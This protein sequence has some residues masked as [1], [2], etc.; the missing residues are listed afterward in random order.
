ME[1]QSSL[2][3]NLKFSGK[4]V[5]ITGSGTGIGQAI[6]KK[7][8]ENGAN[9]VIMGRRKEPLDQTASMLNKIIASAGSSGKVVVFPR[10]DVA[11]EAGINAMFASLK[12]QFGKVDIIVNNAGVSGPVKTFTNASVKEFREAVAIHLTGTFWTS[13]SGL[14]AMERGG[15]IITIAT[16]FTEENRYEQRPYRFRTPYT[17]AQGAKNRLAEALAWELVERDIRSI[18]TN[19]GPVHSDRIYKTVYPKAAAEF[20]RI[21]GYPGLSSIEVEKVT[22][23]ALPLLGEQD[24]VVANGCRQVAVEI[25]KARG[26]EESEENIKKLSETVAGALAKMQEI[27]EKIQNNT[28][29]MI[30]DGEFL[31]QEDVAEMVMNLCDEKIS[32]LINGRVIPND[33]VFY[34]V[35]PIVGTSVDGP[36]QPDLKDKVIILTTSSSAKKDIERVKQVARLAQ[37]AGAKQVIVLANNQSDMQEYR[38]FHN[39]AIN[40]LDEES[41]RRIFNTA[42]TKFGKIDSVIHFTGDYDYNAAFSSLSRSQW[43]ALVNNFIYIPGLITKEAVNAMAPQGAVEE[44]AKYKDSKGTVVIVGPDAPVGKKISGVLRARA[45]VFRGALRPYTA[46]VNQELGDVLGSSIKLHL[47]LAG[48]SEGSEPD[49]ARLHNSILNLAAGVALKRNEAIFY[50]DEARK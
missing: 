2:K 32:K 9:I 41:V 27:A 21:G 43:D 25:A 5:V 13:V 42:R 24:E 12:N 17:A 46:T 47:V 39:H 26:Q 31:T 10:V 14:S 29:K 3:S 19:P 6:A 23:G 48:N 37:G 8:A 20:L 36:A 28:S 40:M 33:R 38:D 4:T 44:P 49:A 34:P 7:F 11:D 50:V 30:V 1:K 22:A 18:S 45:D 35:K 15:K 16:F